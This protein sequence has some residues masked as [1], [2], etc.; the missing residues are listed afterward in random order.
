MQAW[1]RAAGLALF[2]PVP[3]VLFLFTR[4]PVGLVPSLVLGVVLM[5]THR[6]YARPFA[7]GHA[8]QRCLWCGAAAGAGPWLDVGEPFAQTR[9]RGCCQ[10]HAERCA[11]V[12]TWA[13]RHAVFLKI[14]ILGTLG[15][16]LPVA[17]LAGLGHLAPLRF[18]DDVAFFRIGIA[19]TVLPL[20]QLSPLASAASQGGLRTPF[21]LHIQALIGTRA[22]L[23]LFR[24]IGFV[25][26]VLA[27][28][29]LAGR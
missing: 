5:A 6:L 18:A 20:A 11:G 29:H 19:L 7:L 3:I 24:L 26:L 14:G 8:A 12:L 15:V 10:Q 2:L 22:V 28:A 1:M 13:D 21:P 9:W 16:F 17:L 25:W 23:W 4:A 27:L